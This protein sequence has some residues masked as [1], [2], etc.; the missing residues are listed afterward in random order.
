MKFHFPTTRKKRETIGP[1]AITDTEPWVDNALF[2]RRMQKCSCKNVNWKI[3]LWIKMNLF[4]FSILRVGVRAFWGLLL[5]IIQRD[6]GVLSKHTLPKSLNSP[7]CV[8]S[9]HSLLIGLFFCEDWIH[10]LCKIHFMHEKGERKSIAQSQQLFY[11]R[12]NFILPA[13]NWEEIIFVHV[14]IPLS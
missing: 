6:S 13:K 10:Q 4:P 11:A 3:L 2:V 9:A 5:S 8:P 14:T 7:L 12:E 1:K